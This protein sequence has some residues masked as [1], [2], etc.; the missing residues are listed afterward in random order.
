MRHSSRS[1]THQA[2][3]GVGVMA[4][5]ILLAWGALPLPAAVGYSGIGPAVLPWFMSAVLLLCGGLLIW[6][7]RTGGYRE[8]EE[9]S[10]AGRGDWRAMAWVSAGILANAL[11]VTTAGFVLSCSLC[12]ALA[13]RGLRLSEGKPAGGPRQ[14]LVDAFTGLA[15]A[16]PAFWLFTKLLA[17]NLPGL[18]A[19]GWL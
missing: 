17:I 6:H 4:T 7:A 15:I 16:A 9:G 12:F 3:I 14:V 19:T 2:L 11:L 8:L 1:A 10:G 5:G 13:V 18:T